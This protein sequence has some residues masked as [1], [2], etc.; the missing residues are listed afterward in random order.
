MYHMLRVLV[1]GHQRRA[2]VS[3]AASQV[4]AKQSE[5]EPKQQKQG[6]RGSSVKSGGK[7]AAA[8]ERPVDV[9]LLDLRVGVIAKAERHPDADTLYVEQVECGEA[10]PRTVRA[11]PSALLFSSFC[12][13][14]TLYMPAC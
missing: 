11:V 6:A 7:K 5:G 14:F 1:Q 2:A 4:C 8:A 10:V 9:S 12:I 13:G 3:S